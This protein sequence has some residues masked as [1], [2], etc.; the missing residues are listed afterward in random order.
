[1]GRGFELDFCYL[2]FCV[3]SKDC[4]V[5]ARVVEAISIGNRLVAHR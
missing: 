1:M 2:L 3:T 5:C 4:A